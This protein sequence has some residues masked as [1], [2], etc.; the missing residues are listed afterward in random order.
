MQRLAAT[1]APDALIPIIRRSIRRKRVPMSAATSLD[2]RVPM[3]LMFALLGGILAAYGVASN[4]DPQ[5]YRVSMGINV[6]L[7]WGLLIFAFG[8][9][10]LL[11]AWL[12]RGRVKEQP[13]QPK[14]V[15]PSVPPDKAP[16]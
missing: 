10:M 8:L 13:R 15:D 4:S 14:G 6:N 3:G 16:K 12:G 1:D 2:V 7:W 9:L 11:L 5:T